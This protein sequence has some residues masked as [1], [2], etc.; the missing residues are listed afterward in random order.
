MTRFHNVATHYLANYLS[1]RRML[2]RYQQ[3]IQK[4]HCIHE[5]TGRT[6]Q[7]AIGT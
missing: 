2:E 1:W 3:R 4:V 5:V 6:M 7:P